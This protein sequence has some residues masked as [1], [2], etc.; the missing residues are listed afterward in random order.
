[1]QAALGAT[2][3]AGYLLPRLD[4]YEVAIPFLAKGDSPWWRDRMSENSPEGAKYDSPLQRQGE[5][6]P[7]TH[8]S[9]EGAN[10]ENPGQRPGETSDYMT[11]SPERAT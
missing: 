2:L 11:T 3:A 4:R 9:P 7:E 5:Q 8:N 10:H 1:L 6:K